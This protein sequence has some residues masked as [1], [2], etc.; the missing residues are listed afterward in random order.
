MVILQIPLDAALFKLVSLSY[1]IPRYNW[2]GISPYDDSFPSREEQHWAIFMVVPV[3]VWQREDSSCTSS[4]IQQHKK[5]WV[6]ALREL[7]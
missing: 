4:K 3:R 1:E 5:L 6:L 2:P 7:I